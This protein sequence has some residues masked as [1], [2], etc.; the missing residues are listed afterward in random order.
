M[1]APELE[2]LSQEYPGMIFVKMYIDAP[3]ER[4]TLINCGIHMPTFQFFRD[5]KKLD[6]VE[7]RLQGAKI[8]WALSAKVQSVFNKHK[9]ADVEDETVC[10]VVAPVRARALCS[11][12]G[13]TSQFQAGGLCSRY[14]AQQKS[15]SMEGCKRQAQKKGVCVK[16]GATTKCCGQEGCSKQVDRGGKCNSHGQSERLETFWGQCSKCPVKNDKIKWLMEI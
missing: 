13:C 12:K 9:P 8:F 1:V 15:C 10:L 11:H 2:K 14:S 16:H 7:L 3:F 6:E 4:R 5:G